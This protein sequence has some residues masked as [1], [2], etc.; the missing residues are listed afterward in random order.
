MKNLTCLI[1]VL[2]C[3]CTVSFSSCENKKQVNNA[4]QDS[5]E[6][7][8]I[9]VI[10]IEPPDESDLKPLLLSEFADSISY[11]KMDTDPS[12]F[13]SS[14]FASQTYEGCFFG[15]DM[16]HFSKEGK[17]IC[18]VG[19]IGRGPGEYIA[20]VICMG[21]D[22]KNKTVYIQGYG[23]KDHILLKYSLTDGQYLGVLRKEFAISDMKIKGMDDVLL[24]AYNPRVKQQT[25]VKQ[26]LILY[27]TALDSVMD[28]RTFDHHSTATVNNDFSDRTIW[29]SYRD[30]IY[31]RNAFVDTLFSITK[32]KIT[33]CLIIDLGKY[34]L[35]VDFMYGGNDT[36]ENIIMINSILVAS[37]RLFMRFTCYSSFGCFSY[38]IRSRFTYICDLNGKN[39]SYYEPMFTNDLDNGPNYYIP[40]RGDVDVIAVGDV[41]GKRQDYYLPNNKMEKKMKDK[42]RFKRLYEASNPVEDNPIIRTIHW[43]E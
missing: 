39:G 16:L 11:V 43:K 40:V 28:S 22:P 42:D 23:M 41:D 33:P 14:P 20:P 27:N 34:A 25:K 4:I 17:F 19:Q 15:V 13:V 37:N 7:R 32:E 36:Y 24:M 21:V 10:K 8:E 38:D 6:S 31:Y 26:D 18:R 5:A 1:P 3:L 35:P 2:L 9:P 12:Y 29:T 30:K